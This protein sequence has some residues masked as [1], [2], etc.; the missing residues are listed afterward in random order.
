MAHVYD[1]QAGF[2]NPDD[3]NAWFGRIIG[4]EKCI[5]EVGC[6]TGYVGE[7][8][9]KNRMCSVFGVEYVT[10]AA[11]AAGRRN[12]YESILIGDIQDPKTVASLTPESFDFVLFGD[13]LEHLM[14]P[15]RALEIVKPLLKPDGHILIC[16]PST[17]HWSIRLK[18]L[19]GQ[20][21]YADTGPLDR[22]HVH[23]FTPKTAR[24]LIHQCNL[25]IVQKSGVVWLPSAVNKLPTGLRR[26]LA[27]SLSSLFPNWMY[28]QVLLDVDVAR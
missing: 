22:T 4:E 18:V 10:E 14:Q 8:L 19:A 17:V 21:E 16:V 24:D 1:Y 11:E 5:L 13:V 7:Y 23:F 26:S 9:V 2:D 3:K 15:D 12:C 25:R 27:R 6:A 28:G 20:F